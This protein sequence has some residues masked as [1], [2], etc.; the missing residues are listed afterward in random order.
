MLLTGQSSIFFSGLIW[1]DFTHFLLVQADGY[2]RKRYALCMERFVTE[3]AAI[4]HT[5]VHV[6]FIGV[7][8][9]H[10]LFCASSLS[11]RTTWFVCENIIKQAS[12]SACKKHLAY[13]ASLG[14]YNGCNCPQNWYFEI[15][16]LFSLSRVFV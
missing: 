4:A 10:L 7:C 11:A 5:F 13:A 6:M 3:S 14:W 12:Y 9:V 15:L 8:E 2:I 1:D 16:S